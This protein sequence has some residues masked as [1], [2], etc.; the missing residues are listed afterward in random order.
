MD[1][2]GGLAWIL[3]RGGIADGC[4]VEEYDVGCVTFADQSPAAELEAGGGPAREVVDCF[5]EAE[6][7]EVAGVMAEVA[8]ERAPGAGVWFGA[9]QESVTAAG[10]RA[11]LHDGLDVFLV[12]DVLQD[13]G[14]EA[15]F[16]EDA[17]ENVEGILP[18]FGRDVLDG[19]S[20]EFCE[21][22]VL[23]SADFQGVPLGNDAVAPVGAV[24][25]HGFTDARA[26][27]RVRQPGQGGLGAAG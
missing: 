15:V 5:F 14:A 7:A 6:Q 22:R 4:G 20:H 10:V 25:L 13:A 21:R 3:E 17:H 11:V 27:V 19:L 8:R 2:V 9:D 1:A 23:H 18:G 12:T 16:G 26:G 24:D